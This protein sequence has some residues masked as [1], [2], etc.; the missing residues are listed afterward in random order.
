[1]A[2]AFRSYAFTTGGGV[3]PTATEPAGAAT[4]DILYASANATDAAITLPT[5]WTQLYSGSQV[6]GPSN[7]HTL[8]WVVGYI[9]RAGSAPSLQFTYSAGGSVDYYE[10]HLA[11]YS[12]VNTTTAIDAV[13]ADGGSGNV[14]LH[15]PDA[16]AVVAVAANTIA[17]V[18]MATWVGA[19]TGGWT[20]P[21]GYTLR[22]DPSAGLAAGIAEK[23]LVSPGSENPG[24]WANLP[25]GANNS[26]QY[27]DGATITLNPP[28]V[29]GGG[30]EAYEQLALVAENL[31]RRNRQVQV[32]Y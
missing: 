19:D 15:Q 18:T 4:N 32:V 24:A 30:D 2:I 21:S 31:Q 26:F 11:A 3:N 8:Y 5:G 12:G 23:A 28:A 27:W 9:R 29:A 6:G 10:L 25:A 1:M 14:D 13:S 17:L 20:P 7:N 16:S 22:S